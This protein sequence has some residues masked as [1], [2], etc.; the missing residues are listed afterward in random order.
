MQSGHAWVSA[1]NLTNYEEISNTSVPLALI[2]GTVKRVVFPFD[3][4]GASITH[5]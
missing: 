1:D 5:N 2:E 4:L 3:R